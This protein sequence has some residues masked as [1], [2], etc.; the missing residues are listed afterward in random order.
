MGRKDGCISN[1]FFLDRHSPFY[2]LW[3]IEEIARTNEIQWCGS[4]P[5]YETPHI[6]ER[7]RFFFQRTKCEDMSPGKWK[8]IPGNITFYIGGS[9]GN[10]KVDENSSEQR[11]TKSPGGSQ[12]VTLVKLLLPEPSDPRQFY[13]DRST[14]FGRDLWTPSIP[15]ERGRDSHVHKLIWK[16]KLLEKMDYLQNSRGPLVVDD[17][18]VS[19]KMEGGLLSTMWAE[20]V[21]TNDLSLKKLRDTL[22]TLKC[23]LEEKDTESG[24]PYPYFSGRKFGVADF[25]VGCLLHAVEQ[26]ESKLLLGNGGTSWLTDP[27]YGGL[28]TWHEKIKRR[29]GYRGTLE[30]EGLPPDARVAFNP[31]YCWMDHT[32]QD[33]PTVS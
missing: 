7:F 18:I 28:G 31:S 9:Q 12:R 24:T 1:R 4:I 13:L 32:M 17:D 5:A 19:G 25:E 14:L 26:L 22:N 21:G 3:A 33:T 16:S 23:K 2:F 20:I 8:M 27:A 11:T 30:Y 6:L 29:D 10:P 15:E